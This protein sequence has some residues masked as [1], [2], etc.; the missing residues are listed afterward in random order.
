M[1]A[2]AL[3]RARASHGGQGSE[4]LPGFAGGN[5][6]GGS[7]RVFARV[8]P[9]RGRLGTTVRCKGKIGPGEINDDAGM[10]IAGQ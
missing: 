2:V 7:M 10:S 3:R 6:D 4:C 9:D 1:A 8:R 5:A